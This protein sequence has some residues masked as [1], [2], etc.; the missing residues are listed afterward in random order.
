LAIVYGIMKPN[1][2]RK[3]HLKGPLSSYLNKV[4]EKEY[5]NPREFHKVFLLRS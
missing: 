4:V 1:R 5:P 2:N 3:A